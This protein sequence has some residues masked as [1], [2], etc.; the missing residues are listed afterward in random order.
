MERFVV[1]STSL[2]RELNEG[3]EELSPIAK[4]NLALSGSPSDK[5]EYTRA[6]S[7][8]VDDYRVGLRFLEG[9]LER[10]KR[11]KYPGGLWI[12]GKGGQ[13]K[14]F[15]LESFTRRHPPREMR[16]VRT[17]EI[18]LLS[19]PARPSESDILLKIISL[20]GQDPGSV[21]YS[22]N[23]GLQ[24]FVE[25]AVEHCGV[26]LILFD[27]AQ[28][29]W[30]TSTERV[31]RSLDRLGGQLG[32]FLK[33][34]Y[35]NTGV[36]FVFAGTSGL[37]TIVE[38]DPQASTR[39][40]GVLR[41]EPFQNDIKFRGLLQAIDEALP[42]EERSGLANL[43]MSNRIFDAS[44][45]NFRR[46]KNFLAEAVYIASLEGAKSLQEPHLAAAFFQTFCGE[47]TPFGVSK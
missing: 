41:L 42:M 17:C 35:D 9:L 10:S 26:R 44:K 22:R 15:I 18:L 46:L 32:D 8:E 27:E 13:G 33:R 36:A 1:Q 43:E 29:L 30:L 2:F 45:G 11:S 21:H 7:I 3:S 4:R 5:C 40:S 19:F 31:K 20:L 14:S 6:I 24:S 28:H 16:E 39:W 23:S 12:L 34:F 38:L 25:K 37:E 47:E